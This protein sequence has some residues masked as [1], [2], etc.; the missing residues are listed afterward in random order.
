MTTD[1]L[2]EIDYADYEVTEDDVQWLIAEVKRQERA[3]TALAAEVVRL[4]TELERIEAGF[5][6]DRLPAIQLANLAR[7]ALLVEAID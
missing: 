3:R 4:R 7:Q 5:L 1:R 6:N 2:A